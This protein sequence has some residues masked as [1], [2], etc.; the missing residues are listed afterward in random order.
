MATL[1][2]KA[3]LLGGVAAIK[4]STGKEDA[5]ISLLMPTRG[6]TDKLQMVLDSID[7]TV[8]N[9]DGVILNI[10][11]DDDDLDT[12][13]FSSAFT[14]LTEY[15]FCISWH[16]L[17]RT[18]SMG[19]ML[20]ALYRTSRPAEVYAPMTDDYIF[21]THGWDKLI[22][23]VWARYPDGV[24]LAYPHDPTSPG[25][26]TFAIIGSCWIS[27][28]GRYLTNYFPFWFDDV[29]LDQVAQLIGRRI[30]LP[31][32]MEPIGGKGVTQRMFNLWFWQQFFANTLDERIEEANS[33]SR[34]LVGKDREAFV[35][36]AAQRTEMV[37]EFDKSTRSYTKEEIANAE[38][39]LS[40]RYPQKQISTNFRYI[41]K[42][43]DAMLHLCDKLDRYQNID[44][45]V[46]I[47]IAN[48]IASTSLPLRL[49][50]DLTSTA[51]SANEIS[52]QMR[53][54]EITDSLRL[55]LRAIKEAV[56]Q[57]ALPRDFKLAMPSITIG[58]ILKDRYWKAR[59]SGIVRTIVSLIRNWSGNDKR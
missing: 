37:A 58:M 35:A 38:Y 2:L 49:I 22:R 23:D 36:N 5:L 25:N 20:D 19:M 50:P 6:R 32:E 30:A 24:W 21:R 18:G 34:A 44:N 10:Y 29:W 45:K 8:V 53:L 59:M 55:E 27:V 11:V 3:D 51:Q 39:R 4:D 41:G 26:V 31:M 14:R 17:P 47:A 28:T 15:R 43:V 33:L 13:E 16:I 48:N 40:P 46:V 12:I 54:S 42:E 56:S 1:V 57:G 7:A 9:A 52:R